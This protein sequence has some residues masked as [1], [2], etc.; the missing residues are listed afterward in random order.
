MYP[1]SAKQSDYYCEKAGSDTCIV[2]PSNINFY[3]VFYIGVRCT[4]PCTYDLRVMYV[5]MT[6]LAENTAMQS[7]ADGHN[8]FLY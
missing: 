1:A 4:A 2:P 8:S 5:S 7:V 6:V 3:D